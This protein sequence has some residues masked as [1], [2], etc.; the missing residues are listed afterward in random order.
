MIEN[1][2]R[3]G[4]TRV[5]VKIPVRYVQTGVAQG[6]AQIT[7][8]SAGGCIISATDLDPRGPD[9]FLHFSLGKDN[10]EIHLRAHVIHVEI[11][12][13]SGLEYGLVS[14]EGRELLRQRVAESA[15]PED[16]SK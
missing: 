8:L 10:Q 5:E 13:G 1:A 2:G 4:S 12:K 16:S 9:V 14:P 7:Q 11:G 3:R 15:A 6:D